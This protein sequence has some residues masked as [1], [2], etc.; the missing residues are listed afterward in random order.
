[1]LPLIFELLGE[2]I[3]QF[4]IEALVELGF[5]SLAAPFRKPPNKW[6]ASL[7]YLLFGAIAGG[8]SLLVFPNHMVSEPW[9]ILN[10]VIAPFAVGFF[11][12]LM[13]VWRARRGDEVQGIDRFTYGFLF[14]LSLAA[15]R[16]YFCK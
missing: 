6:L 8:L 10:L 4:F 1:M 3:L 11:M 2:I 7:G 14:A 12:S 9:R 13:G 15:I 16:F 5:H